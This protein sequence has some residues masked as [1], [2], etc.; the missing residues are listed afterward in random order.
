MDH[1]K[2]HTLLKF[3]C[4]LSLS[5]AGLWNVENWVPGEFLESSWRVRWRRV[6]RECQGPI[7]YIWRLHPFLLLVATL[8]RHGCGGRCHR[9]RTH[10]SC[11]VHLFLSCYLPRHRLRD[12]H[13]PHFSN[14][15]TQS[16]LLPCPRP[17]GG[18]RSA[19]TPARLRV[20]PGA[21]AEVPPPGHGEHKPAMQQSQFKLHASGGL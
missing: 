2:S 14:E 18:R 7:I 17:I 20:R 6:A 10:L 3:P 4:T 9:H 1:S 8:C 19:P 12:D 5:S 21:G 15:I 11:S 13:D 16:A